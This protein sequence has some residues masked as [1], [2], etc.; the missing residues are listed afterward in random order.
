MPMNDDLVRR[1]RRVGNRLGRTEAKAGPLYLEG[2]YTPT[3]IG[4]VTPGTTTYTTQSGWWT[5]IGRV[6]IVSA[7]ITWTAVTGT[8]NVRLGGLPYTPTTGMRFAFPVHTINVTF[9]NGSVQGALTGGTTEAQ[10]LSPATNAAGT[11]LAIEAA[12]TIRYTITY[13]TS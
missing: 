3:Y 2:T 1:I 8:G 10:L 9:A 12:G 11:E 13:F 6:V 4:S 7:D 5:R